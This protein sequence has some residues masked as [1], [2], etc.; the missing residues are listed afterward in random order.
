MSTVRGGLVEQDWEPRLHLGTSLLS[1][2]VIS[3]R[4]S[5][6]AFVPFPASCVLGVQVF[7]NAA[8]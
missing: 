8:C 5:L 4:I 2:C 3:G 7:S 1:S 6:S